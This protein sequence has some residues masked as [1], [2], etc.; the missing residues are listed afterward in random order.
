M[1]SFTNLTLI[2]LVCA[3][4]VAR[5]MV[6]QSREDG[7]RASIVTRGKAREATIEADRRANI[8][9]DTTLVTIPVAVTDP[10]GRLVT[11]LEK[12]DFRLYENKVV[13]EITQLSSEDV[14]LS[15]GIVFDT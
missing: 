5:S 12:E 10:L 11:G 9:V 8:R 2:G 6:A 3:A 4:C 7:P 13:Q 15:V 14:P 1:H